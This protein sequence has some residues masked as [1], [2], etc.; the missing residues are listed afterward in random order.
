[1]TEKKCQREHKA[2][3]LA[4]A[5]SGPGRLLREAMEHPPSGGW[6]E[7]RPGAQHD[8]RGLS[9]RRWLSLQQ[10][11]ERAQSGPRGHVTTA[12]RG[13]P[14]P[15]PGPALTPGLHLELRDVVNFLCQS[16]YAACQPD[17]CGDRNQRGGA[18]SKACCAREGG[19]TGMRLVSAPDRVRPPQLRARPKSHRPGPNNLQK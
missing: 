10:S 8:P 16:L 1:M 14:S 5:H 17:Y 18:R 7:E 9:W 3:A 15:V 13:Q 11:W 19:R 12:G 4:T 2:S 6:P